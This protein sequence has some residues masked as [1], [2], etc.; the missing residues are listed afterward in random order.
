VR[1]GCDLQ[2]CLEWRYDVDTSCTCGLELLP[3]VLVLPPIENIWL[4]LV[5]EAETLGDVEEMVHSCIH[6]DRASGRSNAF[7]I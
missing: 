6:F 5:V 1:W 3:S 7:D 2:D 4:V